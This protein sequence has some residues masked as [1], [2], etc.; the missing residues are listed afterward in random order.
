MNRYSTYCQLMNK[1]NKLFDTIQNLKPPNDLYVIE[2]NE[3]DFIIINVTDHHFQPSC[4]HKCSNLYLNLFF[5]GQ[6]LIDDVNNERVDYDGYVTGYN[7][8]CKCRVKPEDEEKWFSDFENVN[9][10]F[11]ISYEHQN[12]TRLWRRIFRL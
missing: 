10:L 2:N 4:C 11:Q 5:K 8:L 1:W 12:K 7:A 6:V 9:V 3:N